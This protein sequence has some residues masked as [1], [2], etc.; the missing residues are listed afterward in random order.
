MT[1]YR[2]PGRV[3]LI[4]DHTDYA[5]GLCLPLAIDRET[6]VEAEPLD[7]PVVR[8]RS[9]ELPGEVAVERG[10]PRPEG[11]GRYVWGVA[12]V[13][14]AERGAELAISSTVPLG[15][16]LS[17]SA[18]LE[19]A[20]ALALEPSLAP[21]ELALA[22]IEAEHR[23]GSPCG[24]M[25]QLASAFGAAGHAL[26]LDCS[27]LEVEPVP[28]PDSVEV[29]VVDSG[30]SR[31]LASTPY[32]ERRRAIEAALRAGRE[33][34][35]ALRHVRSEN[36][37]VAAAAEALREGDVERV[38][39]LFRESHD[40]LAHDLVVS[41]PELDRLV[42][43]LQAAGALGARLTGAGFGGAVVALVPAG[44]AGEIAERVAA[45]RAFRV[46]AA[47]GAGPA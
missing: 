12:Q 13:L 18:A 6:V 41:H 23:A 32:A 38:G 29:L 11:W 24:P 1:R 8:A 28:I 44:R 37:R 4:G 16:G 30:V 2:A 15:A 21:R 46:R 17:S 10:S 43:E 19:L 31:E 47:D 25:D 36:A 42:G 34:D 5:G 35:P 7:E 9:A 45:P 27:T 3:N 14:E 40:S 26:L 39:R 33:D 22:C 20:V